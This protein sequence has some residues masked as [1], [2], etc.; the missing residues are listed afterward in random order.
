MVDYVSALYRDERALKFC[1]QWVVHGQIGSQRLNDSL[2]VLLAIAT[3]L[4]RDS[5]FGDK[6]RGVI[7]T[8]L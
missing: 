5:L 7:V 8:G 1:M 2:S 4:V 6:S 3:I